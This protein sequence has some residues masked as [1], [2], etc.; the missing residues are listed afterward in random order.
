M[1]PTGGEA[2]AP[3]LVVDD[4]AKIV[5]LVRTYLE[6]DGFSVVEAHDGL[7]A[8]QAIEA[9]HPQ[10]VVLDLMLPELDGLGVVHRV[11][12]HSDVPILMLSARGATGDRVAGIAQGADDYL[13]KP[14]SPAE[15]VVRVRAILRRSGA[16]PGRRPGDR[17]TLRLADLCVDLD[18]HE[19]TR[20]DEVVQL[21]GVEFRLLSALIEAEGRVLTRDVLIDMLYTSGGNEVFDRTIDVHI[22]RLRDKLGDDADGP[23]YIATVRGAG[24]RAAR[25]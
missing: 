3:I 8:L 1:E 5:T 24:Y 7:A 13:P 4:D 21:T 16:A 2:G 17:G 12:Q 25:G 14:F 20:G 18:R 9:N 22:R 11:R 10:L 19:V 15:L 23:R 6:R